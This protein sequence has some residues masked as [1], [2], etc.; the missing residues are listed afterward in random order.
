MLELKNNKIKLTTKSDVNILISVAQ[1]NYAFL[2]IFM[3]T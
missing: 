1:H 3:T 2:M